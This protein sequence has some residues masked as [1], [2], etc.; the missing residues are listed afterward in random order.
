[1]SSPSLPRLATEVVVR[2]FVLLPSC[3][4][5][6]AL[7]CTSRKFYQIWLSNAAAISNAVLSRTIDC[8]AD[9]EELVQ[10]QTVREREKEAKDWKTD[11]PE[12]DEATDAYQKIL[13]R[14]QRFTANASMVSK[15]CTHLRVKANSRFYQGL[16]APDGEKLRRE[17]S[18]YLTHIR[19][20]I[21]SIVALSNDQVA[22]D[23]YLEAT[24][25][26]DLENMQDK[27]VWSNPRHYYDDFEYFCIYKKTGSAR[28]PFDLIEE[29]HDKARRN[30]FKG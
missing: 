25:L 5:V 2:I 7:N 16:K 9:A 3:R 21:H 4:A 23:E 6:A 30:F 18:R 24:S 17:Y 10:F 8:Y 14:N 19:Y 12:T 22:Q 29:A 28:D 20:R 27:S 15:E 26:D 1:M 13:K 11:K